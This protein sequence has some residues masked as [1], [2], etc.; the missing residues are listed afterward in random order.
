MMKTNSCYNASMVLFR[1]EAY[2]AMASRAYLDMR[3]CGDWYFWVEL[4]SGHRVVELHKRLNRFRLHSTST[5]RRGAVTLVP[6]YESSVTILR[7]LMLSKSVNF[8]YRKVYI[9]RVL[10][11]IRR[12][13][14]TGKYADM[15]NQLVQ[16]LVESRRSYVSYWIYKHF[17]HSVASMFCCDKHFK[18]LNTYRI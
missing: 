8:D 17:I 13:R 11:D 10:R 12:G 4:I 18:P 7:I 3:Y 6:G 16:P 5:T 2:E 1:K 9:Y 15:L 14:Y